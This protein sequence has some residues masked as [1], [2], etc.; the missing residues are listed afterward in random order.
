VGR[1]PRS[2]PKAGAWLPDPAYLEA[3]RT[4]MLTNLERDGRVSLSDIVGLHALGRADEAFD[5]VERASFA[6]WF[7][8]DVRLAAEVWSPGIIFIAANRGIID[9][10]RFAHLCAK[11][12]L[13]DYC[14]ATSRWPDCAA[15]EV[16]ACDFRA[17]CQRFAGAVLP[18]SGPSQRPR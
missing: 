15:E 16:L 18:K 17:E 14:F 11:L 10:P 13:V 9:D 3:N 5:F 6:Q 2:S 4:R 12:G 8:P 1:E 7:D